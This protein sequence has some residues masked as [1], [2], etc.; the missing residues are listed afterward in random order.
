MLEFTFWFLYLAT[1]LTTVFLLRIAGEKINHVSLIGIVVL[2]MYIFSIVGILPLFYH[3]DEYRV[4]TGVVDQILIF[5]V[6]FYSSVNIIFLLVGVLIAKKVFG[7]NSGKVLRV[8]QKLS[9][10]QIFGVSVLFIL[11]LVTF[12]LYLT[13]LESVAI[14]V[15]LASGVKEAGVSRSLMGNDFSGKYHWYHLFMHDAS[16]LIAFT[17][18]A[19]WL[20]FKTKPNFVYFTFS[21]LLASFV[22]IMATEKGPMAWFLIGLF[23]VYISVK[24]DGLIPIATSLKFLLILFGALV[25]M[26][27]YFMNSEDLLS[28]FSSVFSRSFTG[29]ITPAYFYLQ[30]FP[31]VKDFLWGATFPNPGGIFPFKPFPYTVEL[32]NWVFPDLAATGVV[33]SMPTVF[34]CESYANFG[35]MGIPLV[36]MLVG[37]FLAAISWVINLIKWSPVSI[38]FGVWTILHYKDLSGTGFSGFFVDI[39]IFVMFLYCIIINA[40]GS[41]AKLNMF[42]VSKYIK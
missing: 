31:G 24:K 3:F 41:S 10:K 11:S 37:I 36:A 15:A 5:E 35:A 22:A 19:N 33:G 20:A 29:Q 8:T 1:P 26:Y 38:G 18:Y 2:S 42:S 12:F 39:S 27:I 28:A 7:L 17:L 30:Y 4:A 34:W 13:Q 21:F 23:F 14:L 25:L 6:L 40:L 32:M 16:Q 9:N